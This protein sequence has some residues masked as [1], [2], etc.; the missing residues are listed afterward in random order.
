MNP[1]SLIGAVSVLACMAGA[2]PTRAATTVNATQTG[3]N[4]GLLTGVTRTIV[5]GP[6]ANET[7]AVFTSRMVLDRTGGSSGFSLLGGAT[8][9]SFVAFCIEP[10]QF[11]S[12]NAPVT[13]TV[14]P[15]S[16]AANSLGGIGADKADKLRELF[17]RNA[18][19]GGFA[20]MT[21]A[22]AAALQVSI[23]EIVAET[24]SSLSTTAGNIRFTGA[25]G[26]VEVSTASRISIRDA[27]FMLAAINGAVNAPRADNLMLLQST[28]GQDLL[29][30]GRVPEPA[31]WA[32]LIAGFGLVGATMRRR[33]A[34]QPAQ[35]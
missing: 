5:S 19:S 23:W 6:V 25:A 13:Y 34:R 22:R 7:L 20:T 8:K 27:G 21:P 33:R 28:T 12:L 14:R 10:Q 3:Y 31:S 30:F 2:V 9:S 16:Q 24:S 18:A 29:V 4:A 1:R 26:T 17:G 35:A 11:I 32:M 15:L